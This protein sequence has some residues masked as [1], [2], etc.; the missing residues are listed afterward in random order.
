MKNRSL[1]HTSQIPSRFAAQAAD[2]I[3]CLCLLLGLAALVGCA[4]ATKAPVKTTSSL[5]AAPG[6]E[7]MTATNARPRPS[8]IYISDF[9]LDPDSLHAAPR[10]ARKDGIVGSRLDRVR[11]TA[12]ELRGDDPASRARKLI[13]VL[14]E[15]IVKELNQAGLRAEY[16]PNRAGLRKEFHPADATLPGAGWLVGGWFVN[17]QENNPAVEATV[18]FGKGAGEVEIAV[19]VYDLAQDPRNPFL[20]IGTETGQRVKPGALVTMNPYAMGAKFLLARGA[21][22]KDVK[23]QGKAIARNL[24]QFIN[25]GP[26]ER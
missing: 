9:Y 20:Y 13:Q 24:V 2:R 10:L 4:T 3:L 6:G 25:Q 16:A 17:V 23:Q 1:F 14:S 8:V 7:G 5:V 15:T 21:T 19:V 22:E 18:G 11:G 26:S 12:E